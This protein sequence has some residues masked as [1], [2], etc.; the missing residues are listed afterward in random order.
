MLVMKHLHCL[1]IL[2]NYL[3]QQESFPETRKSSLWCWG[4]RCAGGSWAGF[5]LWWW[6][7]TFPWGTSWW[8][9]FTT[10]RALV[11]FIVFNYYYGL[12][13]CGARNNSQPYSSIWSKNTLSKV[14][15]VR[16]LITCNLHFDCYMFKSHSTYLLK[17]RS[18]QRPEQPPLYPALEKWTDRQWAG[19]D[20]G[21]RML[22]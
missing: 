8:N 6:H 2:T 21:E 14:E 18:H 12:F 7:I 22:V 4:L 10:W 17:A 11:I 20:R 19:L 9:N 3:F 1:F 13:S 15:V 16:L 5:W